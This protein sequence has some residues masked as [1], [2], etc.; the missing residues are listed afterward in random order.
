M[1]QC[2]LTETSYKEIHFAGKAVGA[3]MEI[4]EHRGDNWRQIPASWMTY[5]AVDDLAES[6]AKIKTNGESVRVAPFE[7]PVIG[8]MSVVTDPRGSA[9]SVIQF[10]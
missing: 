8:E 2:P 4:N 10:D 6:V 1:E 7:A 9:F 3:M 5:I